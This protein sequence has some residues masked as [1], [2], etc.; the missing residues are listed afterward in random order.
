MANTPTAVQTPRTANMMTPRTAFL[1]FSNQLQENVSQ[2]NSFQ[3]QGG[4]VEASGED[5]VVATV[6]TVDREHFASHKVRVTDMERADMQDRMA[7]KK[8]AESLAAANAEAQRK[9]K[10]AKEDDRR[11]RR[12]ERNRAAVAAFREQKRLEKEAITAA[13][14][15]EDNK[16]KL[17][18]TQ[19]WKTLTARSQAAMETVTLTASAG[20]MGSRAFTVKRQ[21]RDNDATTRFTTDQLRALTLADRPCTRGGS[22]HTASMLP[23]LSPMSKLTLNGSRAASQGP[24]TLA[25]TMSRTS[26]LTVRT[27]A[28]SRNF[29]CTLRPNDLFDTTIRPIP[30]KLDE[31]KRRKLPL[32]MHAR[33]ADRLS[34]AWN[35]MESS[36]MPGTRPRM[37]LSGP[38]IVDHRRMCGWHDLPAPRPETGMRSPP[39]TANPV[40]VSTDRRERVATATAISPQ[41]RMSSIQDFDKIL[42]EAE[43]HDTPTSKAGFRHSS[44][45]ID[46]GMMEMS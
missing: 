7:S 24:K 41:Q 19:R 8:M 32:P 45:K 36:W 10:E 17:A 35:H 11:R 27:L 39:K 38:E 3:A 18:D 20:G 12:S 33:S 37:D 26:R 15:E 22:F 23:P 44:T 4:A 1:S 9:A 42:S 14:E 5:T 34:T 6:V 25:S 30:R 28:S 21:L 2:Q 16:R 29:V 31:K 13:A 46:V 43:D 40:L